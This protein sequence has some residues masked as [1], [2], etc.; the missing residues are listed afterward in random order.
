MVG[1]KGNNDFYASSG[2]TDRRDSDY[3]VI[4]TEERDALTIKAPNK[5][6]SRRHFIFLLLSFEEKRA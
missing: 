2:Q 3:W 4:H 1:L 5:N 6:C